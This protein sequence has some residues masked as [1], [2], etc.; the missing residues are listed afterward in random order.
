MKHYH[1]A[2][3]FDINYLSRGLVLYES[4]SSVLSQ[5]TLYV[6]CLDEHTF[7]ALAQKYT[8]VK[9]ITL[10]AIEAFEPKLLDVKPSRNRAEYIFTLSP[11][12]PLYLLEEYK[13]I[14]IITTLD[15]DIYFY[16]SPVPLLDKLGE[17]S[18]LITPHDF[19]KANENKIKYGKYNVSFQCFKNDNYA[20]KCLN[21]WKNQCL[22]W[23]Y[24]T[25]ETT[26]YA[27]QKYLDEF[28]TRFEKVYA[29]PVIGAG[30]APWNIEKYN[31][32]VH[33]NKWNIAPNLPLIYYHFHGFRILNR[34]TIRT[35]LEEYGVQKI[36]KA[37]KLLYY[38]YYKCLRRYSKSDNI[39]RYKD[40]FLL[41]NIIYSKD[42][43]FII[44][45][46]GIFVPR[47]FYYFWRLKKIA[48]GFIN[49]F[50]NVY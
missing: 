27:D 13:N 46:F 32:Q 4:L 21:W 12:L 22:D 37:H 41:S 18:I 26:R 8:N 1:F 42:Y 16:C 23:C 30:L 34:Y 7:D 20:H 45:I 29:M 39:S 24:D 25:P 36:S 31:L 17:Y 11:I 40:N 5:F 35:F 50:K 38:Q 49:K 48:D 14:D 9:C 28:S 33:S 6:L 47:Q 19:A 44:P 2:T 10:T 15:A 43:L 3:L